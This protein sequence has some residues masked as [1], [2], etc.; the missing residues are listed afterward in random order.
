MKSSMSYPQALCWPGLGVS[1]GHLALSALR[2]QGRGGGGGRG[3]PNGSHPDIYQLVF[4]TVKVPGLTLAWP[5]LSVVLLIFCSGGNTRVNV[6]SLRGGQK[7][8]FGPVHFW[9]WTC[10]IHRPV[11]IKEEQDMFPWLPFATFM[12]NFCCLTIVSRWQLKYHI[13][14]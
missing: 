7:R 12:V 3:E 4:C 5:W 10:K 14:W 13:N 6:L 2:G 1:S 11:K 9:P 8:H